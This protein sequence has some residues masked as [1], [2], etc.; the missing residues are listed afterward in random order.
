M[1][2]KLPYYLKLS[3]I[4]L[5]L[6]SPIFVFQIGWYFLGKKDGLLLAFC[7][8]IIAVTYACYKFYIDNWRDED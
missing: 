1:K 3:I 8:G 6:I 2:F 4:M 7:Y 5:I